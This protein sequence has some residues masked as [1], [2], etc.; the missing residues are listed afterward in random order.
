MNDDKIAEKC[1]SI[2]VHGQ[3]ERYVHTSVGLCGRMDTIQCAIV[4][5]KLVN[6]EWEVMKRQEIASKY[7]EVFD[8][9]VVSRMKVMEDRTSVYAQYTLLVDNREGLMAH[10]SKHKIPYAIHYPN[11]LDKQAPYIDLSDKREFLNADELSRKVI[12]IPMHPYLNEDDQEFISD[13]IIEF[14]NN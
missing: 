2:R 13:T 10:M 11:T 6:F 12:S 9:S 3:K 4:L 7:D 8:A 1:K 5:A 14:V